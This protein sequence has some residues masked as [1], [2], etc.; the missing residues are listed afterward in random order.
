[1]SV[2]LFDIGRQKLVDDADWDSDTI[3]AMQADLTQTDTMVKAITAASNATPIVVT[4]NSHGLAN[5]DI[6]VIFGVLGNT[7]ANGTYAVAN[8]ATNT[9]ELTTVK[10]AKNVVGTAAY[11]SGGFW[12]NLG[13]STTNLGQI[14][15]GRVATDQTLASRTLV[16]G[17]LDAADLSFTS[18]TGTVHALIIYKDTGSAATSPPIV[19]IDGKM[20]V[21]VAADAASSATTLWV[22]PLAGAV[23]SGV[24][25]M[26]SAGVSVTLSG[27]AVAGARSL[28]VSA[29]AGAIAAGHTADVPTTNAGLP[30]TA[31]GGTYNHVFDNGANKIIKV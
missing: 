7:S 28:S 17:V 24:V 12:V 19:F 25:F 23:A 31:A 14:D 26:T 27:S 9:F 20:L 11:T 2:R 29:L 13:A 3:K 1:M 8:V 6:V 4:S 15:A 16:N 18:V 22:E 30:F 21:V 10:D 5:G